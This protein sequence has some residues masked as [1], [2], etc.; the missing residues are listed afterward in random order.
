MAWSSIWR[1]PQDGLVL[2]MA[3]EDVEADG[4]GIQAFSAAQ[5]LLGG[6]GGA[7]RGFKFSPAGPVKWKEDDPKNRTGCSPNLGQPRVKESQV[8]IL[9]NAQFSFRFASNLRHEI[10]SSWASISFFF[11]TSLINTYFSLESVLLHVGFVSL[12][13]LRVALKL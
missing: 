3:P 6:G 13:P 2:K 4:A 1:R 9:G 8:E 5:P 12:Q 10:V 11:S 7:R